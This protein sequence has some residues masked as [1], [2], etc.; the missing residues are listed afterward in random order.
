[1]IREAY[2][3]DTLEIAKMAKAFEK[4]SGFVK[5]D[6]DYT[7]KKYADLVRAGIAKLFVYEENGKIIGSIGFVI[8][9]DFH[10]GAKT[11]YET[12]WFVDP[13]NRGCGIRLLLYA[14]KWAK[15]NVDRM[16]MLHMVDS[17]PEELIRLYTRR[18]YK[19][20]EQTFLL[21]F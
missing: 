17:H 5:V 19:L 20:V 10:C 4:E 7:A 8:G 13:E 15:D 16:L 1:M 21:E 14:E 3:E 9:E 18:G 12:Y 2:P 6:I 11:A